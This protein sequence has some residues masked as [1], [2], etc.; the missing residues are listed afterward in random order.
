MYKKDPYLEEPVRVNHGGVKP[1][2][3]TGPPMTYESQPPY[4]DQHPYRDYDH[5]PNRYD[6]GG[7]LEPKYRNFDSQ[8]HHEKSVP[9]YD[10]QWPPYNQQTSGPPPHQQQQAPGHGYDPRLSYEDGPERDYS[11]PQPRYDEAPLGYNGRP[12]YGKPAGPGPIR[13]DESPPSGP[14]GYAPLRY[15]QE[16]H[17][18]PPAT[19]SPEP[20]KQYYQGEPAQ[21]T[22][23]GPAYNQAPPQHRGYKPPPQQYEPIMNFDA[24]VPTPKP[25]PE[26]LRPSPGEVLLTTAPNLPPPPPRVEPEDDPAIRAQSVLSRVKM[27]ENKRSVSVDRAKEAVDAFGLRVSIWKTPHSCARV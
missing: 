15:D 20:P 18:Y 14:G 11:P 12:R 7:Y 19:R 5:P 1:S 22:G 10:D 21:R 2:P 16:P 9:H 13:Y 27:F 25:Q 17:P 6:G 26:A 23:P 24:P 3:A 8:L 4:Q